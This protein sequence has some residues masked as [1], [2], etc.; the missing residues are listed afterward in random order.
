MSVSIS[1]NNCR[2]VRCCNPSTSGCVVRVPGEC[3]YY[4]GSVITG[5]SINTGDTLNTLVT[6]IINYI[7]NSIVFPASIIPKVSTDFESDGV[8]CNIPAMSGITFEIFLND[9]NRFIY[10]EI[11]NQEWDYVVGGGFKILIPGFDANTGD[12]HLYLF[13]KSS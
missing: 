9:L 11:G 2:G 7:N 13:P 5:P 3:T 6:K 8:T 10:N 4:S 1:G 12:Y